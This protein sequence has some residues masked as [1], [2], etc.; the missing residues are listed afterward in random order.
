MF[1]REIV[2]GHLTRDV[3]VAVTSNHEFGALV[4]HVDRNKLRRPV[5][6]ADVVKLRIRVIQLT[7]IPLLFRVPRTVTRPGLLEVGGHGEYLPQWFHNV[8][9]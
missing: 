6:G 4:A 2:S 1:P 8:R 7:T 3:D 5:P 9:G